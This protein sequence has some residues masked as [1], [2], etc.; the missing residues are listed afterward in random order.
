MQR[1]GKHDNLT[2]ELFHKGNFDKFGNNVDA[3]LKYIYGLVNNTGQIRFNI[4]YFTATSDIYMRMGPN[5]Y[6]VEEI[7]ILAQYI[8]DELSHL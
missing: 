6:Q 3:K 4:E 8:Q 2:G 7:L 1:W 5:N